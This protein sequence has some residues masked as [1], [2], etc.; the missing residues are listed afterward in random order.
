MGKTFRRNEGLQRVRGPR[1]AGRAALAAFQAWKTPPVVGRVP[2]FN[3]VGVKA[4]GSRVSYAGA[5]T[6]LDARDEAQAGTQKYKETRVETDDGRLLM[7][8][9]AWQPAGGAA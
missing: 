8:F 7:E 4:D 6:I 9:F 5:D 3:V 2:L 1:L